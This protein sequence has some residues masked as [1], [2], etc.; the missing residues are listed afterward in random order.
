MKNK[1]RRPQMENTEIRDITLYHGVE[2][3]IE[4]KFVFEG[5]KYICR[6]YSSADHENKCNDCCFKKES[7]IIC[8]RFHCSS[9]NREDLKDVYFEKVD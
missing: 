2:L 3:K 4:E 8:F 7:I 6:E 5:K 9:F 1:H